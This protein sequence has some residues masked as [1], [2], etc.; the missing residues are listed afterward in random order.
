VALIVVLDRRGKEAYF[1]EDSTERTFL[2][3]LEDKKLYPQWTPKTDDWGYIQRAYYRAQDSDP[4]W[5]QYDILV[6]VVVTAG[7]SGAYWVVANTI[8]AIQFRAG[9]W[10]AASLVRLEGEG[11]GDNAELDWD[12]GSVYR[13]HRGLHAHL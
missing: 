11:V 3:L 13:E 1:Y 7:L 10:C 12:G 2:Q 4:F 8:A 9:C 5:K 6:P